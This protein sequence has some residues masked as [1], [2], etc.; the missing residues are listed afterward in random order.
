M[1]VN[2]GMMELK[3]EDY[4]SKIVKDL[5]RIEY[6][7]GKAKERVVLFYC[8]KCKQNFTATSKD[9]KLKT[10]PFCKTCAGS[11]VTE[12]FN[13]ENLIRTSTYKHKN[14][15]T[16]YRGV[17]W[18]EEQQKYRAK[19]NV[20]YQDIHLGYFDKITDAAYAY[21]KYI[22]THWLNHKLNFKEQE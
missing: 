17:S 3:Q 20:K 9:A 11:V 7:H 21:D 22:K 4:K 1:S 13:T 5:G 12:K 16:T 19:I 10:T 18:N 15:T 2:K 8:D 14:S 6:F